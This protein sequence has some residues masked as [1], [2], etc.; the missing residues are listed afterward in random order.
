MKRKALRFISWIGGLLLVGLLAFVVVLYANR[1]RII[2]RVVSESN[3]LLT[4]P[5]DVAD[6]DISIRKFPYAS[7]ALRDVYSRGNSSIPADTLL[8]A[9]SVYLEFHL[10]KLVL[11]DWGI[12]RISL[13]Q[14]RLN[15][16]F[17]TN[18]EPNYK[19]WRDPSDSTGSGI[20][21]LE[22][23]DLANFAF[24][25]AVEEQDLEMAAAIKK[26]L[27][28]GI[29]DSGA[30][31]FQT[32]SN[33]Y[34]QRLSRANQSLLTAGD[35]NSSLRVSGKGEQVDLQDGELS[36]AGFKLHFNGNYK[37][38]LFQL[39][40]NGN[41][42][43]L[44]DLQRF[45]RQ[46]SWYDNSF[47][48]D[49][50]GRAQ[51]NFH[52]SFPLNQG[53]PEYELNF[54]CTGGS[55]TREKIRL[56]DVATTGS[57]RY[58]NGADQLILKNF[59]ARGQS[60]AISG[61]LSMLN[62][63]SPSVDLQLTSDLNMDEW[64]LILPLDTIT[65][66]KG[67]MAVNV[68]LKNR[69]RSLDQVTADELKAISA[70]GEIELSG[71]SFGFRNSDKTIKNLNASLSFGRD[72]LD[73][74]NFYF[75]TGESDVY[76]SGHF[77]N[78]WGYL[79]LD[80]QKL[81][82][83][84]RVRAQEL[85]VEDFLL[86]GHS[87][88]DQ[89][90]LDFARS[91][92]MDLRVDVD[93]LY[94]DSFYAEKVSGDLMIK[95]GMIRGESLLFEADNGRFTGDFSINMNRRP[96]YL[97]MASMEAQNADLHELFV[98]FSNFGQD[99]LVADNI[100]GRADLQ[101]RMRAHLR[102]NLE[103]PPESVSLQAN[104]SISDGILKNY[105]PMLALSDYAEIEELKE[106][107]F[108]QLSNEI[109]IAESVIYIP[110]MMIESN[111]LNLQLSGQH[112]F[113]NRINYSMK[114]RLADVLFKKRKKDSRHSE[115]DA[116]LSEVENSDDPNIYVSMSGTAHYPIISLDKER[117]NQSIKENLKQQGQELKN[118][119]SGKD[120]RPQKQK[121]SGIEYTLFDED[122]DGGEN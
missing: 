48:A 120:N 110:E 88:N 99:E 112:H 95:D 35:F 103:I 27:L 43:K 101:T 32:N 51:L 80:Q 97:F 45:L 50:A 18:A 16:R 71:V 87:G 77:S 116:H 59:Q 107:R 83:D 49:L 34:L 62:L 122:E 121:K 24:T 79:F 9:E 85:H 60:G 78:V 66:P 39:A 6:I 119:L 11:G 23:I 40:V 15:L 86:T 58:R 68:N 111:V 117:M 29:F 1:E 57:Y 22:E 114:L 42:L 108:R 53:K 21:K 91:L 41:K 109:S 10:W 4:H 100:Y 64:L 30:F 63:S 36:F 74:D 47:T 93:Q 84:T 26:A 7:V 98:S 67:R 94:F 76:L 3:K 81:K 8:F 104:L 56:A 5:V 54:G 13:D 44:D 28:S 12:E 33:F 75:Q 90:S 89:Y 19:I 46:Q 113:D 82:L 31:D 65:N 73:I 70:D 106:V 102:P 72:Q 69:F 118:I 2:H 37:P 38:E 96:N 17:P 25:L 61:S 52:G 92:E 14:G 20:F 115:F 55:L 105:Q